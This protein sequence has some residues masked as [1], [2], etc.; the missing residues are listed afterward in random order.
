[1]IEIDPKP[2]NGKR[3]KGFA[4]DVHT[5]QSKLTGADEF[6]HLMFDSERSPMGEALYYLKYRF[7]K[8]KAVDIA[9][10]VSD[11]IKNAWPDLDSIDYIV[12]VPPSNLSRPFQPVQEV[13]RIVSDT[14]GIHLSVGDLVKKAQ[15][16][17]L[18]DLHDEDERLS[19]LSDAFEI[20]SRN[21]EDKHILLF[22]DLLGSGA[23]LRTIIDVLYDKA[24]VRLVSVLVLTRKRK[25]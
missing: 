11:F 6:G 10:T 16:P 7:D 24:G 3:A 9:E 2:L 21:L 23:T 15:T 13:A 1:M 22:D 18:K 25:R 17:Q 14:L 4:L 19:I 20:K 8:N 12:P 5:I